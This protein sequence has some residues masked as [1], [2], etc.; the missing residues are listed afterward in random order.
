MGIK[1]MLPPIVLKYRGLLYSAQTYLR[2][3]QAGPGRNI[4]ATAGTNLTKPG[5]HN[6]VDL[7]NNPSNAT[8]R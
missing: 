7:C 5:A 6:K 2:R 8:D 1:I 3:T 4:L